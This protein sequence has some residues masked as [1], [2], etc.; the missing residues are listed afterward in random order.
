MGRSVLHLAAAVA[1]VVDHFTVHVAPKTVSIH[2]IEK[3]ADSQ[4]LRGI[5]VDGVTAEEL[6]IGSIDSVTPEVLRGFVE[7]TSGIT[8][9]LDVLPPPPA[10]AEPASETTGDVGAPAAAE[11]SAP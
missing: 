9:S 10:K 8:T 2:A 11:P 5:D 6:G 3:D 4:T 7:K 1:L